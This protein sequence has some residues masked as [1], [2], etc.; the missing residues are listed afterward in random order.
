MVR[1]V[2]T[3]SLIFST[4]A[5]FLLAL[6]VVAMDSE[7]TWI[8]GMD[9]LERSRRREVA[10][11]DVERRFLNL[12]KSRFWRTRLGRTVKTNLKI[13]S[14]VFSEFTTYMLRLR[15]SKNDMSKNSLHFIVYVFDTNPESGLLTRIVLIGFHDFI[16]IFQNT[17]SSNQRF[18]SSNAIA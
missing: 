18:L 1:I 16:C 12:E 7:V 13:T 9:A 2:C 15:I 10:D 14:V 3:K 17:M 4:K 6:G 11:A 5:L 8:E